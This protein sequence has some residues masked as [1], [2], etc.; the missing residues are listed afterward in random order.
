MRIKIEVAPTAEQGYI[1]FTR[2]KEPKFYGTA[3]AAG[4][5]L[6]LN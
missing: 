1:T 4:D 3:G 6:G 5:L 2:T